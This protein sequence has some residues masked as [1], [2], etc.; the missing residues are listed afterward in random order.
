MWDVNPGLTKSTF[1]AGLGVRAHHRVDNG[2]EFLELL[3]LPTALADALQDVP[4]GLTSVV[5]GG[6]G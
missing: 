6:Q 1:L 5:H 4:E 2:L 3:A